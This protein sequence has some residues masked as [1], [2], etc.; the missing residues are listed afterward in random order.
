[1]T[2]WRVKNTEKSSHSFV[3]RTWSQYVVCVV[4][5]PHTVD[6]GFIPLQKVLMIARYVKLKQ[7]SHLPLILTMVSRLNCL[8]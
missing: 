6:T 5:Q 7:H 4:N 1:M 8:N 2:Q 3:W